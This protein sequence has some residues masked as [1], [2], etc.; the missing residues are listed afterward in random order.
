MTNPTTINAI[1]EIP[2][3]TPN[4]IGRT[5]SFFPGSWNAAVDEGVESAAEVPELWAAVVPVAS[6]V[7]VGDAVALL[8]VGGAGLG[9]PVVE[10]VG[11]GA[12]V[13]G[14]LLGEGIPVDIADVTGTDELSVGVAV[15]VDE[16]LSVDWEDEVG[17][18][19]DT[20]ALS[21]D[22]GMDVVLP[23]GVGLC[24]VVELGVGL[25]VDVG[26]AVDEEVVDI[27]GICEVNVPLTLGTVVT[28]GPSS[29]SSS[30]NVKKHFL[31]SSTAGFPLVSVI[32]VSVISHVSVTGPSPVMVVW[33]VR[34]VVALM[35]L[36]LFVREPTGCAWTQSACRKRK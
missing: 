3:K 6:L 22:T 19:A 2:A 32:G 25:S 33:T 4:P 1:T 34:R 15:P 31:T 8:S 28:P 26:T 13:F 36:K 9:G 5:E 29:S 18:G 7:E 27:W 30:S 10:G 14:S 21:L 35:F 23:V 11:D 20:V 12:D 16:G 24:A 17:V